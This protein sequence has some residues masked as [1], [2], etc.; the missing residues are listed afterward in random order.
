MKRT[1]FGV[2]NQNEPLNIMSA[3]YTS[4]VEQEY[5]AQVAELQ[6]S[7]SDLEKQRKAALQRY[8]KDAT[9]VQ[10]AKILQPIE[11]ALRRDGQ[12][13]QRLLL[14]RNNIMDAAKNQA[15]LFGLRRR[16]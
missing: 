13:L 15:S 8:A 16:A 5:N 11:A 14:N 7:I 6:K 3:R 12:E 2:F 4:P 9:P 1:E 10:M